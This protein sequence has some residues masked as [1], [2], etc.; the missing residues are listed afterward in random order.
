M[1]HARAH[2]FHLSFSAL[3]QHQFQFRIAILDA[4]NPNPCR[5]GHALV[6]RDA[7]SQRGQSHSIG[8][9]AHPSAI[10]LRYAIARMGQAKRQIPI[11]RQQQNPA[12]IQI[13]PAGRKNPRI[14][15][16]QQFVNCSAMMRIAH[17]HQISRGFVQQNISLPVN[18][19]HRLT[20]DTHAVPIRIDPHA[21]MRHNRAIEFNVARLDEPLARPARRH[22]CSGQKPVQ[23]LCHGCLVRSRR[24]H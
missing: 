20:V 11:I 14:N 21:R 15:A 23:P 18:R 13:E 6:E 5:R 22:P 24:R 17:R 4:H 10:N 12:G 16:A 9:P 19:T 3:V 8:M 1:A 7:C 2:L